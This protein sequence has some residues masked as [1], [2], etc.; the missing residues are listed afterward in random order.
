MGPYEYG[1]TIIQ[2]VLREASRILVQGGCVA[3]WVDYR[4]APYWAVAMD[5]AVHGLTRNGDLVVV[6]A[7]GNPGKKQHPMKHSNIIHASKGAPFFDHTKM[8][9]ERRLSAPKPGYEGDKPIGSVIQGTM[10]NTDPQR[11]GY[12]DQKPLHVCRHIIETMCPVGGLVVDPFMG[13][14]TI[15]LQAKL[16]GMRWAG[17]DISEA[18]VELAT[19]RLLPR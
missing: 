10:S 1:K 14:G 2:P 9:R 3:I 6:S 4:A 18:A 15:L 12:P 7:L 8:E 13:S 5:E 19:R 11:V 17:C 16:S